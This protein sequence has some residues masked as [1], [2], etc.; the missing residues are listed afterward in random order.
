LKTIIREEDIPEE[1]MDFIQL[2]LVKL[3]NA[4]DGEA[5][6]FGHL[7]NVGVEA[8]LTA[9]GLGSAIGQLFSRLR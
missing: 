2:A 3:A 6:F 1:D 5:A 9:D 7:P 8:R 4:A